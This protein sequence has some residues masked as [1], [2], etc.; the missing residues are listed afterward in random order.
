MLI[1]VSVTYCHSHIRAIRF[2]PALFLA[3][4][5]GAPVSR[6]ARCS[7]V[8][9]FVTRR[10]PLLFSVNCVFFS[11]NYRHRHYHHRKTTSPKGRTITTSNPTNSRTTN[12]TNT[13]NGVCLNIFGVGSAVARNTG[14]IFLLFIYLILYDIIILIFVTILLLLLLFPFAGQHIHSVPHILI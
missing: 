12:T 5:I 1:V 8:D 7:Y 6:C 14:F 13:T 10:V 4:D 3:V 2:I 11:L 9:V